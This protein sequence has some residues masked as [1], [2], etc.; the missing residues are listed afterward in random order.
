MPGPARRHS[1][2]VERPVRVPHLRGRGGAFL[3]FPRLGPSLT[4]LENSAGQNFSETLR[5]AV[6]LPR[7]GL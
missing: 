5:R 1:G 6:V 4:V 2:A 7:L 3:V